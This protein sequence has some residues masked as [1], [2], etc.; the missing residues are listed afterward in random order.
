MKR[1]RKILEVMLAV[2]FII[3]LIGE[4][5]AVYIGIADGYVKNTEG[6]V[7]SSATVTANVDGCS[8]EGCTSSGT[9]NDEGYYIIANLNL[10]KNGGLTVNAVKGSQTGSVSGVADQY[11]IAHLDILICD[12]P[13]NPSLNN[14]VDTHDKSVKFSWTSGTDPK[15]K[16]TFD[17]FALNGRKS[18]ESSG[19]TEEL[20]FG[21]YGW[22][23]RTCNDFCCSDFST[24]E[25]KVYNNPPTK[26]IAS[27][28]DESG[29]IVLDWTSGVDPEEDVTY[30]EFQLGEGIIERKTPPITQST[31]GLLKWKV[32]TCDTFGA[33]SSWSDEDSCTCE[34][35]T[36][37][38]PT[39][40]QVDNLLSEVRKNADKRCEEKNNLVDIFSGEG[41]TEE[42]LF[43]S[44]RGDVWAGMVL[45]ALLTGVILSSLYLF[46]RHLRKKDKVEKKGKKSRLQN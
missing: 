12:A 18:E 23:V 26:P 11:H 24:D 41:E 2:V 14:I 10:P 20:S 44:N 22:K 17:E 19:I 39:M 30:D 7:V 46:F 9:S 15:G 42:N 32:R 21:N 34:T 43:S 37:S 40:N 25:F 5:Q 29:I 38:C 13:S 36:Q 8:I 4:V 6:V 27:T 3:V 28:S 45:G 1:G 33:C 35:V 16:S 31:S